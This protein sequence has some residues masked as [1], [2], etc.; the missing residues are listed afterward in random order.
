MQI[1]LNGTIVET[2]CTSLDALVKDQG[3]DPAVLIVE[4]NRVVVKQEDW[5]HT[6][7]RANDAIELLNFVGG[8]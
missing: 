5:A 6:P 1:K 3:L 2:Q 4:H 8:G 7:V